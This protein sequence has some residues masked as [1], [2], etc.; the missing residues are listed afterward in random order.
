MMLSS[1]RTNF[2]FFALMASTISQAFIWLIRASS[3]PVIDRERR[4][5]CCEGYQSYGYG[6]PFRVTTSCENQGMI[7][8]GTYWGEIACGTL[9]LCLSVEIA[10]SPFDSNGSQEIDDDARGYVHEE[11]GRN[12]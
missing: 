6:K 5:G 7:G 2:T 4:T 10:L 8:Q 11:E 9:P 1:V 3:A 12:A